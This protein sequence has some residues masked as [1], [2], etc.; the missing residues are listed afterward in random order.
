LEQVEDGKVFT[1][2]GHDSFVSRDDQKSG[3]YASNPRKHIID[4]V[5]VTW[6]IDYSNFLAV[7]QS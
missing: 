6:H 4:K 7:W 3:I 5:A 1:R 2:L